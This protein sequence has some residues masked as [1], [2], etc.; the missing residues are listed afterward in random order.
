MAILEMQGVTRS[1]CQG[2]ARIDV[3]RNISLSIKEG[4]FVA[5]VGYSGS[6]KSTLVA[7][8]AGLTPPDSGTVLFRGQPVTGADPARGGVPE[9]LADA[10][11]A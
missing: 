2:A 7:T 6:G 3:L 9:L 4:E 11:A 10:L 1:W 5:L 8:L